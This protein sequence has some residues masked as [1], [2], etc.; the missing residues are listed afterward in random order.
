MEGTNVEIEVNAS[1]TP[2]LLYQWRFNGNNI[3]G[4]TNRIYSIGTIST[5]QTGG[6]KV[7]VSNIAGTVTSFNAWLRVQPAMRFLTNVE[8][9]GWT[10][11][12]F[13][14]RIA[15][16]VEPPRMLVI[17]TSTNLLNWFGIYTNLYPAASQ[18]FVDFGAINQTHRF[19]RAVGQYA[20][21]RFALA[22]TGLIDLKGHNL[23]TDSFDSASPSNSVFGKYDPLTAKSNGDL[24]TDLSLTNSIS[25]GNATIYGSVATGPNGTVSIGPGGSI[26]GAI[27]DDM[28]VAFDPVA[29]PFA[30]G[31]YMTTADVFNTNINGTVYSSAFYGGIYRIS[32][33]SLWSLSSLTK[34]LIA[35]DVSIW[36]PKGFA[37]SGAAQIEIA[38]GASLKIYTGANSTILGNGILNTSDA[39][40]CMIYGLSTCTSISMGGNAGFTGTIYAPSADLLI[41]PGRGEHDFQG[42]SISKSV[43]LG[44]NVR[45]HY[46]ENLARVGPMR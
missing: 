2:P 35:G 45:I 27:T 15:D 16:V 21:F 23:T 1:G 29:V 12:G 19:Y 43:S 37:M 8:T 14:L 31:G 10:N 3:D 33:V 13:R 24:A 7:I 40:K 4:A 41:A 42:A 36:L 25:I 46:D 22:A 20:L 28:N 32:P 11:R 6:Y 5:N 26:T 34:V 44:A 18:N 9:L 17:E 38:P 39:T 30:S